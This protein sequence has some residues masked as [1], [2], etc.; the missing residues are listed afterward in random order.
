MRYVELKT[1]IEDFRDSTLDALVRVFKPPDPP[2]SPLKSYALVT[3]FLT[4]HNGYAV[5]VVE[6]SF[7]LLNFFSDCRRTRLEAECINDEGAAWSFKSLNH[8]LANE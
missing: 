3:S 1:A 4:I 8:H 6:P 7:K 5:W 2:K